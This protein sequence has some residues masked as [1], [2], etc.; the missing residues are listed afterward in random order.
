MKKH[1]KREE[2]PGINLNLDR[3]RKEANYETN[4]LRPIIRESNKKENLQ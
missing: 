2:D 1:E 3:D 4:P